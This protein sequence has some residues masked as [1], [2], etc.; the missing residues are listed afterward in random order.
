MRAAG[1]PVKALLHDKQRKLAAAEDDD[2]DDEWAQ[3]ANAKKLTAK[4]RAK[5]KAAAFK[6]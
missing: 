5:T 3:E 1:Q 4:D 2:S 6:N